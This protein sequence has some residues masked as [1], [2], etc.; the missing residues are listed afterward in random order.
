MME[1]WVLGNWDIGPLE[2]FSIGMGENISK[3]E[4]LPIKTTFQYSIIPF[5]HVRGIN[6]GP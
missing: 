3:N 5:F 4:N 2:K 1:H 6:T